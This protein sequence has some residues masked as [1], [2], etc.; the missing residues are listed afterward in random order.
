L[1]AAAIDFP[2]TMACSIAAFVLA[3]LLV[4]V[5]KFHQY[6]KINKSQAEIAP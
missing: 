3:C 4:E 5:K 2:A 6:L 1:F